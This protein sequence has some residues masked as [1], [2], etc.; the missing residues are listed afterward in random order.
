ME[1][2]KG[3]WRITFDTNPYQCNHRCIMCEEHSEHSTNKRTFCDHNQMDV[4]LI[5]KVLEEVRGTRLKEIIPSTMGEPLLY[6]DFDQVLKFCKEFDVR[7]NLTTNGSFPKKSAEKW[8]ELIIPLASDVK[9]SWNGASKQVQ[10][11]IMVGSNYEKGIENI[12]TFISIRDEYFKRK[13]HY[14]QITLQLTF[15]EVNLS[16]ISDIVRLGIE[17]GVDRVKGH[18][19]WDHYDQLKS[20]SLRRNREAILR[21]NQVVKKVREIA[22]NNLL[23]NGK[24]IFLENFDVLEE[25][26]IENLIP[27]GVCPFLGKEA[28]ISFS[29]KFSPCCAP[30]EKRCSLGYFGN[31]NERSLLDI[32]N[33][34][35]YQS[36]C[37]DYLSHPVCKACN[38]R[39]PESELQEKFRRL[40]LW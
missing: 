27:S 31:L 26:A 25:I 33:D 37:R 38:M 3:F 8:A 20:L 6:K 29:G 9:I 24:K 17:F 18:H 13:Q 23:L 34:K 10:E 11:S 21:W 30:E 39:R 36:L 15:M 1:N 22:R 40:K 16:E 7:L 35:K 2:E 32:W 12:K 28:W 4:G 14:C 19:L 5:K